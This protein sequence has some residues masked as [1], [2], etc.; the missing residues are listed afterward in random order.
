MTSEPFLQKKC[1]VTT[2]LPLTRASYHT[3]DL[4]SLNGVVLAT[5]TCINPYTAMGDYSRPT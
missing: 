1:D 3:M 2:I 5:I 4:E